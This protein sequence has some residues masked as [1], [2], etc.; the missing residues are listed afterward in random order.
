MP[1]QGPV[2]RPER[3]AVG[4][5]R[6]STRTSSTPARAVVPDCFPM[7]FGHIGDGNLHVSVSP[8][9]R[10]S[11]ISMRRPWP[12]WK[13]AMFDCS[14]RR[15]RRLHSPPSTALASRKLPQMHA[16]K[17]AVDLKVMRAVKA[18]LDP[19]GIMNPGKVVG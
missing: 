1:G 3:C 9:A 11:R 16:Y 17:D 7:G 6:S 5:E 15:F 13:T 14:V 19:K 2:P 12:S 8:G 10:Q 4:R 18:A